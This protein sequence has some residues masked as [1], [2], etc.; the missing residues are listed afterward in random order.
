MKAHT[1]WRSRGYIPH[2]DH[3]DTVQ[4]VV[5]RLVD[6]LPPDVMRRIDTAPPAERF[7][8]IETVLDAEAGSRLLANPAAARIV[9]DSLLHF[10]AT[11]YHLLAWCVMPTHVHVLVA[12]IDGWLL[13]DVVHSW[14]SFTAHA[15]NTALRRTGTVWSRE[16]FDRMMRDEGQT[17]T[18]QAYI[19]NN[20]VKAGLCAAPED[21]R[22]SSAFPAIA[23]RAGETP[24]F[25]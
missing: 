22:W 20:P 17:G 15:V 23:A 6:S 3:P 5:F 14:K 12:Q 25:R 19:E 18:A 10:D 7:E 9:Q 2:Y 16:Y 8:A 24:A 4:H 11:R 21:W 1:G 13:A